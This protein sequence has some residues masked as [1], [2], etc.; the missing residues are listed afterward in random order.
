MYIGETATTY[1]TLSTDDVL[2]RET[3]LWQDETTGEICYCESLLLHING[4]SIYVDIT[5]G[6]SGRAAFVNVYHPAENDSVCVSEF[7]D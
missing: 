3:S 6:T 7:Y 5:N 2:V 4:A 1:T